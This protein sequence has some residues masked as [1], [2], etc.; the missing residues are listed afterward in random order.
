MTPVG[1]ENK[2][3]AISASKRPDSDD[4]MLIWQPLQIIR[5]PADDPV[6][7]WRQGNRKVLPIH[8]FF[9]EYCASF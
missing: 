4:R 2:L 5:M 3:Y 9:L 1:A 6:A 8:G 7:L